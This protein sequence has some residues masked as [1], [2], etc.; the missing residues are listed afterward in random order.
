MQFLF[1]SEFVVFCVMN[2]RLGCCLY[3]ELLRVIILTKTKKCTLGNLYLFQVKFMQDTV[4]RNTVSSVLNTGSPK[5]PY[6]SFKNISRN[7][8]WL[9]GRHSRVNCAFRTAQLPHFR[10]FNRGL[11][12]KTVILSSYMYQTVND[13]KYTC[14]HY[15]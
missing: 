4:N 12:V 8:Y 6:D 7:F 11:S 14:F 10:L 2:E 1:F 3:I 9:A 15:C 5:S 13:I